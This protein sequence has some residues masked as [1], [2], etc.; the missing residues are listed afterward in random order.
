M[1]APRLLLREPPQI[2]AVARRPDSH[3]FT[4]ATVCVGA[5]MGQLDASIVTLALPSLRQDFGTNLGAIEWV[6]LGYMLVL[7]AGVAVVGRIA[8]MAGRKLL[9]TYGFLVF[10]LGSALAGL[11][12]SLWFLVAARVIQGTGAAMLQANSV[13]LI[14]EAMPPDRLGRGVGIQG[15]AQALGLALGPAAG[16]LLL[17]LGGWRLIFLVNVPAG[18][19]GAGLGWALLPR[20]RGLRRGEPFDWPGAVLFVPAVGLFLAA[21][22]FGGRIGWATVALLIGG[23]GLLLAAF[24]ARER[25]CRSPMLDLR[26]F[27]RG[28]FSAG[29]ASGLLSYLVLFGVM[30]AVP[31]WL[32]DDRHLNPGQAGAVLTALPVALGLAAPIAGRV[33]DRLGPRI[34]TVGGM[35]LAAGSLAVLAVDQGALSTLIAELAAIGVGLGFF[36]P[37]NNASIM[38][39]APRDQSGEASGMLNM[40][41]GLGSS[42]GVALTGLALGAAFAAP[43]LP[44]AGNPLGRA[45]SSLCLMAILAAAIACL[46]GRSGPLR[47]RTKI[48]PD[49][50]GAGPTTAASSSRRWRSRSPTSA[51]ASPALTSGG[52]RS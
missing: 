29:I 15:A 31:F 3:W 2:S 6:A 19:L 28:A 50:L 37:A 25:R 13:A 33:A 43:G 18:L 8:D 52:G 5:F 45:A 23:S 35:V 39:S 46:R 40:T 11:A 36:I 48:G 16:G 20:S 22:S 49:A 7:V 26:L 10:I 44:L 9:Y 14:T 42:L 17:S 27:R 12:P 51:S 1:S 32:E 30:L 47:G 4:V 41:R 21:L 24:L 34:P 38:R